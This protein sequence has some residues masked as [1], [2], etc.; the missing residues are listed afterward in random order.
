LSINNSKKKHQAFAQE[1]KIRESMPNEPGPTEM[2]AE[3]GNG[4]LQSIF[5]KIKNSKFDWTVTST[6]SFP[7][8]KTL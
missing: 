2:V 4:I 6:V 8:L 5:F 1:R 3:S 7:S